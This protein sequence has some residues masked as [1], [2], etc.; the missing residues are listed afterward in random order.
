[1][2]SAKRLHSDYIYT[3]VITWQQQQSPYGRYNFYGHHHYQHT[4]YVCW[5]FQSSNRAILTPINCC[6]VVFDRVIVFITS[7]ANQNF[8]CSVKLFIYLIW[9]D[10]GLSY[11]GRISR[12]AFF[13]HLLSLLY[14]LL[15]NCASGIHNF[16]LSPVCREEETKR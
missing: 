8:N 14:I 13:S 12:I 1:M 16:K 10:K 3:N 7:K 6:A 5:P 11:A 4:F 15:A 9:T 2:R